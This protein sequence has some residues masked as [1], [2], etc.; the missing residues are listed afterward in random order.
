MMEILKHLKIDIM[1]MFCGFCIMCFIIQNFLLIPDYFLSPN[2]YRM[3]LDR[4]FEALGRD[5][6]IVG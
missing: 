5:F 2:F 1:H 3:I 4:S 6:Q